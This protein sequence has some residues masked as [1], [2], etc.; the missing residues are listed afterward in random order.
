M[1]LGSLI[2]NHFWRGIKQTMQKYGRILRGLPLVI[3][4]EVLVGNT[5]T[6]CNFECWKG[7]WRTKLSGVISLYWSGRYLRCV[8]ISIDESCWL[9]FCKSSR[10]ILQ[11]LFLETLHFFLWWYI[12]LHVCIHNYTYNIYIYMYDVQPGVKLTSKCVKVTPGDSWLI[13]SMMSTL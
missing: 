2:G 10:T 12:Y 8:S 6:P 7:G 5:M 3:V 1:I 4:H 13:N 11:A 9:T